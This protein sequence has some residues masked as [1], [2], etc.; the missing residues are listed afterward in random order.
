MSIA[1]W[2]FS[3][4]LSCAVPAAVLAAGAH[5]HGRAELE[6]AVDGSRLEVRLSSPLDGLVGFEHR[7]RNGEERAALE[8]AR[9][10]LLEPARLIEPSPAAR[11]RLQSAEVPDPFAEHQGEAGEDAHADVD[12][13]WQFDCAEADA[14]TAIV[15]R[16]GERFPRLERVE[17]VFVGPAGQGAATLPA[18]RGRVELR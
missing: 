3:F 1:K 5:E 14:L 12:A 17:A 8:S 4:L 7:P 6:I 13:A 11:C 18:G 9:V 10:A 16:L 15:I 2:L